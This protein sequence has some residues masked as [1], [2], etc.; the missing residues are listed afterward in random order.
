MNRT[1]AAATRPGIAPYD[2]TGA[3][4]IAECGLAMVAHKTCK[5]WDI[6]EPVSGQS[7]ARGHETRAL[8]VAA[9][10]VT[11]RVNGGTF[12][13]LASMAGCRATLRA[14]LISDGAFLFLAGGPLDAPSFMPAGSSKSSA[15]YGSGYSRQTYRG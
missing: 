12:A 10:D 11:I 4:Y 5:L 6:S 15:Y 3:E 14:P 8:A 7:A 1:F 13:V 2:I 9:A